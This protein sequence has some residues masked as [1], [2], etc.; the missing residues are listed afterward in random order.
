MKRLLDEAGAHKMLILILA[1]QSR[2]ESP[3][4]FTQECL[5]NCCTGII[6]FLP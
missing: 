3:A 2:S 4:L 5:K 1:K 6:N